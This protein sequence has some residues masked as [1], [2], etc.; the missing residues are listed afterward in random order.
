MK[1]NW[2][3]KN[4]NELKY[5]KAIQKILRSLEKQFNHTSDPFEI[6]EVI[7]N[8]VN[9]SYFNDYCQNVA[10]SMITLLNV[11]NAKTWREAA[12]KSSKG[13]IIYK[14]L[15]NELKNP[16]I[17]SSFY[18]QINQNAQLIKSLPLNFAQDFTHYASQEALKGRRSE[19]IAEDLKKK[20]RQLSQSRANLIARTEVSK[21]STALTQAR[22]NDLSIRWYVWRTSK[23]SRVRSAHMH[24]DGVLINWNDAPNP[25]TLKG[26][27]S[28]FGS[29]QA[30]CCPNCRCY[31]QPL[32][33]TEEISW[34]HKIY[35][36][37]SIRTITRNNFEKL[38]NPV[39]P[40]FPLL[41]PQ[42]QRSIL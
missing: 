33:S 30:G 23:D 36:N 13:R 20:Y 18:E 28:A 31:A 17:A 14:S 9:N 15:M 37:G 24:M 2:K 26:E 40:L 34:P 22:C 41:D 11:E 16:A 42:K 12:R 19:Y 6:I 1:D 3:P 10:K 4:L 39:G 25:E 35:T 29:Y 21:V 8:V 5:K 38:N 32:V 7:K 27:K